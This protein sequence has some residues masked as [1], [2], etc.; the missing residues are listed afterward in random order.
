MAKSKT[1][2]KREPNPWGISTVRGSP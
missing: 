1:K 2:K